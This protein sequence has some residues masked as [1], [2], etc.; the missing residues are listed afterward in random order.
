MKRNYDF[1]LK[2]VPFELLALSSLLKGWTNPEMF[3][4]KS[5]DWEYKIP[6]FRN[7]AYAEQGSGG[8]ER[9]PH[10]IVQDELEVVVQT[11]EILFSTITQKGDA[12]TLSGDNITY[13][14]CT[15]NHAMSSIARPLPIPKRFVGRIL[16]HLKRTSL[17]KQGKISI[18]FQKAEDWKLE[19]ELHTLAIKITA[20]RLGYS[21]KGI[22]KMIKR[23]RRMKEISFGQKLLQ[24]IFIDLC[25]KSYE[26]KF[27]EEKA[28]ILDGLIL[29]DYPP[30][31]LY[32]LAQIAHG[33][34]IPEGITTGLC[35]RSEIEK[36]IQ[37]ICP[38]WSISNKGPFSD[39]FYKLVDPA[40]PCTAMFSP[41]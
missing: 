23:P 37:V 17:K 16:D 29:S 19:D 22:D 9:V 21:P 7:A 10:E 32:Y 40:S 24:S 28:W 30:I 36:L 4:K 33:L 26:E 18:S 20:G 27:L 14:V 11:V 2:L 31:A 41:G 34:V 13:Q 35:G 3:S 8:F 39:A 5:K 38:E 1:K 25:A 12:A 6:I 15:K